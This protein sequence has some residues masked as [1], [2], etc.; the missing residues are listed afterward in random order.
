MNP[1]RSEFVCAEPRSGNLVEAH[2]VPQR[3]PDAASCGTVHAGHHE[4]KQAADRLQESRICS[5]SSSNMCSPHILEGLRFALSWLQRAVRE[6]RRPLQARR[7]DRQDR[8]RNGWKDQAELYRAMTGQCWNRASPSSTSE[9]PQE[10]PD[11]TRSG[12][13]SKVPLRD[14]E[15]RIMAFWALPRRHGRQKVTQNYAKASVAFPTCCQM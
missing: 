14:K 7:A 9:E 6:R 4:R 1:S 8:F 13:T 2:S 5:S 3:E 15:N 10:T 11:G 12:C